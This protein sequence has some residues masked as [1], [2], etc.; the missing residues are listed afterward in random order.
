MKKKTFSF[1]A[2]AIGAWVSFQLLN[3]GSSPS[4]QISPRVSGKSHVPESPRSSSTPTGRKVGPRRKLP[5]FFP[6]A[7]DNE[8]D[9]DAADMDMSMSNEEVAHLALLNAA[10][11][12]YFYEMGPVALDDI[13]EEEPVD[14]MWTQLIRNNIEKIIESTDFEGTTLEDIQCHRTMCKYQITFRDSD[15]LSLFRKQ[16]ASNIALRGPAYGFGNTDEDGMIETLRYFGKK[17]TEYQMK[18][19]SLAKIYQMA[20]GKSAD[21]IVPTAAQVDK[22]AAMRI[23]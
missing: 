16:R 8:E 7:S 12:P 3:S 6:A 21:N 9:I 13:L 5:L 2:L 19:T 17:G 14:Y 15:A 22:V 18:S 20:T 4:P 11:G 10:A 1:I 23:H